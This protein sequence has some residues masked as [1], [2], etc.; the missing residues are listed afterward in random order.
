MQYFVSTSLQWHSRR[1]GV[2]LPTGFKENSL[3]WKQKFHFVFYLT[4]FPDAL[5]CKLFP[6]LFFSKEICDINIAGNITLCPLCD[7]ACQYQ[8]LGDS[9]IFAK[10]TFLF[11]NST[12]LV[13]SIFMSFWGKYK[14]SFLA[15]KMEISYLIV[16]LLFLFSF[17]P[18]FFSQ[19][20]YLNNSYNKIIIICSCT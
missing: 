20:L 18:Y 2:F 6:R 8:K 9:C 1:L 7:K 16:R 19:R 13:F 12:T 17:F 15:Q 11:D 5:K 3:K 10:I 14:V 4:H